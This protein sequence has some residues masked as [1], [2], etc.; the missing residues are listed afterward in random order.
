MQINLTSAQQV[1]TSLT[2][3]TVPQKYN[4]PIT[5]LLRLLRHKTTY[6]CCD[7]YILIS[8]RPNMHAYILCFSLIYDLYFQAVGKIL[9]SMLRERASCLRNAPDFLGTCF[10]WGPQSTLLCSYIS[11]KHSYIMMTNNESIKLFD[12]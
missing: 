11:L 1:C 4:L 7:K 12:L 5:V 9:S 10:W 6:T 2:P 8:C 3:A